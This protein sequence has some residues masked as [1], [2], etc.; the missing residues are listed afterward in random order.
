MKYNSYSDLRFQ[1]QIVRNVK[2][3]RVYGPKGIDL[4]S[5]IK[6]FQAT[7]PA[8]IVNQQQVIDNL[9]SNTILTKA[10]RD[11]QLKAAVARLAKLK[12]LSKPKYITK[13]GLD[14]ILCCFSTIYTTKHKLEKRKRRK[15]PWA[16]ISSIVLKQQVGDCYRNYIDLL[17]EIGQIEVIESYFVTDEE[18]GIKGQCKR[19]RIAPGIKVHRVEYQTSTF[20]Q[21][22]RQA[23][24]DDVNNK[25]TLVKKL[26]YSTY[27]YDFDIVDLR[28]KIEPLRTIE[29]QRWSFLNQQ[30]ND[31]EDKDFLNCSID[32]TG[33]CHSVIARLP[34][35]FLEHI[36]FQG[37]PCIE[38]DIAN[39]QPW[40]HIVDSI[41][42]VVSSVLNGRL[43]SGIP[44]VAG[45]PK[46]TE[47]YQ[48]FCH[49]AD[50]KGPLDNRTIERIRAVVKEMIPED[51]WRVLN[52][53]EQGQHY[54][55]I[56]NATGLN[57][58]I[59]QIKAKH[60]VM[61]GGKHDPDNWLIKV[62]TT[63]F[64]NYMAHLETAKA[65]KHNAHAINCM[66]LESTVCI[67]NCFQRIEKLCP[68][69][70]RHDSIIVPEQFEQQAIEIFKEEG[71]K[72]SRGLSEIPLKVKSLNPMTTRIKRTKVFIYD[73][74]ARNHL[75]RISKGVK[76][77]DRWRVDPKTII[78]YEV[79]QREFR[80]DANGNQVLKP[81]AYWVPTKY[82]KGITVLTKEEADEIYEKKRNT[83][84]ANRAKQFE[85]IPLRI[86]NNTFDDMVN[87]LT[88]QLKQKETNDVTTNQHRIEHSNRIT[89]N[90]SNANE[91]D[92]SIFAPRTCCHVAANHASGCQ[93]QWQ[94]NRI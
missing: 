71:L 40:V 28:I 13:H 8:K 22:L 85:Q 10:T 15:T 52:G 80:M 5:E 54:R 46:N 66:K 36:S 18:K 7:L 94:G 37:K 41:W 38:I 45:P 30:I 69:L 31:L 63:A 74:K 9:E 21:K 35:Y 6:Q 29:P 61:W 4:E 65:V 83:A 93:S 12:E 1:Q 26:I 27:Q 75:K 39:C 88:E 17:I 60:M 76:S 44:Y 77:K 47:E 20:R 24:I 58:T 49:L 70:T 2:L 11:Q 89:H 73:M 19:M 53:T 91:R 78:P 55:N 50:N 51:F 86:D 92:K 43:I 84:R 68:V 16:E 32:H 42:Q 81:I 34:K 62:M 72:F 56:L 25:P 64:P 87:K 14:S 3:S 79:A 59:E 57:K 82:L 67:Q 23:R 48:W 33:R 90:D